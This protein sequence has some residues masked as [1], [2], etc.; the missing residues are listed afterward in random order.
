MYSSRFWISRFF[1]FGFLLS[2][3]LGLG[4][5]YNSRVVHFTV[6]IQHWSG[7][8]P[9]ASK[10]RKVSRPVGLDEVTTQTEVEVDGLGVQGLP[11]PALWRVINCHNFSGLCRIRSA[12]V[13]SRSEVQSAWTQ[14]W[15]SPSCKSDTLLRGQSLIRS[16]ILTA[17]CFPVCLTRQYKLWT[18]KRRANHHVST[19]PLVIFLNT[20]IIPFPLIDW[21]RCFDHL[22]DRKQSWLKTDQDKKTN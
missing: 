3:K 21:Y 1:L 22:K 20:G 8:R 2:R 18:Y 4:F 14:Q 7:S 12:L 9:R 19:A 16:L 6:L 15:F 11:Q 10:G 17:P 5:R 13:S